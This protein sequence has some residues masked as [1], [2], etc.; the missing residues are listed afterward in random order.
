MVYVLSIDDKPLMPTSR[1]GWVRRAL[2]QKRIKVVKRFPFTVQLLYACPEYLQD[3]TLGIDPGYKHVG[4]SVISEIKEVF[5]AEV[6][7]RTNISEKVTSRRMYRRHR[8]SRNTRYRQARFSNRKPKCLQPSIKHKIE[9][10][11]RLISLVESIMPISRKIIENNSFNM[12]KIKNPN[13]QGREY[14]EGP[15]LDYYNTKQYVLARDRYKCQAKLSGCSEK[16]HVHHITFRRNGGSDAERNLV[17]LCVNHHDMLHAGKISPIFGKHK[18]LKEATMMNIVRSQLLKRN[19]GLETIFGYMTKF[20]RERLGLRKSHSNDA[21][22]ITDGKQ[23]IRCNV[24]QVEQKRK[25]NRSLQKNRKGYKP[26][27]RRQRYNIQPKDII[28]F[29]GRQG[30][31]IGVHGYGN[32]VK[33]SS[34]DTVYSKPSKNIKLLYRQKGFLLKV[35]N[36]KGTNLRSKH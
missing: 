1:H 13:I 32:Q 33:F 15:T 35:G 23:Q 18:H 30:I 9:S 4:L 20:Y 14:Q 11:E 22:V 25:N 29:Q 31:T 27:I 10:H 8:R 12:A 2:K 6:T 36:M 21:F 28:I 24:L 34:D 19:P 26:S 7:L 16:L 5:S 3:L 17:T